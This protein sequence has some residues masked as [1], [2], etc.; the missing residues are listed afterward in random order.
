MQ[1][2]SP[3]TGKRGFMSS[4]QLDWHQGEFPK[5]S[6]NFPLVAVPHKSSIYRSNYPSTASNLILSINDSLDRSLVE[7]EAMF[8]LENIIPWI[9]WTM[10]LFKDTTTTFMSTKVNLKDRYWQMAVNKVD[11]WNFAYVLQGAGSNDPVQLVIPNA[12]QLGWSKSTPLSVQPP[13]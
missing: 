11:A 8:E 12:L 7:R 6:E 1:K 10:A 5:K 2:G 9:I 3:G 4:S 13:K